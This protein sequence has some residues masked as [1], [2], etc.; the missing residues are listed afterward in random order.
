[1]AQCDDPTE[2][3]DSSAE[4]SMLTA[5]LQLLQQH[6]VDALIVSDLTHADL[7][8]IAWS[9]NP[10][11][12]DTVCRTLA[13]VASGAVEYVCVRTLD[14]WPIAKGAIDYEKY[15]GAGTLSQL[16]T[17][18]GLQ[19]MGIGSLLM[20]SA[21]QRIVRRGLLVAMLGVEDD[22]HRA[23]ALYERQGYHAIGRESESWDVQDPGGVVA[24]HHAE[25]TIMRKRLD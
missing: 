19:S 6:G 16:A 13:R 8:K 1:V 4:R 25:V 23:R 17:H 15:E 3:E 12:V 2:L 10:L 5:T 24:T 9:G 21:E 20:A 14:G 11:H 22:H 18:P 7:D